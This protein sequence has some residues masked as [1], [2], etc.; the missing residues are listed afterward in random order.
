M[1]KRSC[2]NIYARTLFFISIVLERTYKILEIQ[3]GIRR[4]GFTWNEGEIIIVELGKLNCKPQ[5]FCPLIE[6][7]HLCRELTATD[8]LETGISAL[9]GCTGMAYTFGID[10][11]VALLVYMKRVLHAPIAA[12]CQAIVIAHTLYAYRTGRAMRRATVGQKHRILEY[13]FKDC[14]V[15]S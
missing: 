13:G 5:R 14:V 9:Y 8:I 15:D 10:K 6:Q 3:L 1:E 2:K 11:I 7:F 4:T 12:G